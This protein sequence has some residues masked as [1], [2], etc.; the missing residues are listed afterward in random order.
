MWF[1]YR[2]R[3]YFPNDSIE[4]PCLGVDM[5]LKF[6]DSDEEERK[7]QSQEILSDLGLQQQRDT[8]IKNLSHQKQIMLQ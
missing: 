4:F 5:R 3:I 8:M 6:K 7:T 1:S 2:T